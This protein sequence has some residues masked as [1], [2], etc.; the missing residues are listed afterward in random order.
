MRKN[1][2]SKINKTKLTNFKKLNTLKERWENNDLNDSEIKKYNKWVVEENIKINEIELRLEHYLC[3]NIL[4]DLKDNDDLFLK[5]EKYFSSKNLKNK[6]IEKIENKLK[7]LNKN[8]S[9]YEIKNLSLGKKI[10]L[11]NSLRKDIFKNKFMGFST[12]KEKKELIIALKNV[13]NIRNGFAH[14]KS[15]KEIFLSLRSLNSMEKINK[16]KDWIFEKS[17][18]L[19]RKIQTKGRKND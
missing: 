9:I 16:D 1:K 7:N 19:C 2:I 11:W 3:K 4:V 6:E 17:I 8:L 14:L 10:I 5:K 15:K 18:N 12:K 13:R